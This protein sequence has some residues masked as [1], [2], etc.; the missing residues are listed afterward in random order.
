VITLATIIDRAGV[1]SGKMLDDALLLIWAEDAYRALLHDGGGLGRATYCAAL[2][3]GQVDYPLPDDWRM[4][5]ATSGKLLNGVGHGRDL[6][7]STR[8]ALEHS[9]GFRTRQGTPRAYY[10]NTPFVLSFDPV[11]DA[12]AY[13]SFAIDYT[14]DTTALVPLPPRLDLL[15]P[16]WCEP[17]LRG[18]VK[19]CIGGKEGWES[20]LFQKLVRDWKAARVDRMAIGQEDSRPHHLRVV[21]GDDLR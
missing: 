1:E 10:Y 21:Q 16:A 13:T 3:A 20:P 12:S 17:G 18:Y 15:L 11:P 4:P 14:Q 8:Q 5:V 2:V 19:Y 6:D 7:F 9:A